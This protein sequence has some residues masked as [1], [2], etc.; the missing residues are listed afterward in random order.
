M[1]KKMFGSWNVVL[2]AASCLVE[3]G[4]AQEKPV[5]TAIPDE[6][7][8]KLPEGVTY[9]RSVRNEPR[10]LQIH[11]LVIDM[12]RA[13][14]SFEVVPGEDPDGDGPAEVALARPEDLA[15]KAGAIA[16]INTAA[17]AMLVD[18]E[19]G[20]PGKYK[21]GGAADISGWVSQG[22]RMISPPQGGYWSVWMDGSNR[23]S[24]GTISSEKELRSKGIEA[25]W[26]VSGFRGILKD[27]KVL[28]DPQ[29][30][31]HPRTAV[32]LSADG[33]KFVWLVV[34]G[35]QKGYSE[36]VSEEELA[37]LLLDNGC[38]HGINLDG[39][40]SSSMWIRNER[41]ELALANRPSDP[42][43]VRPVPVI[44]GMLIK[45]SEVQTKE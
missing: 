26:A 13:E 20:K 37:R 41:S 3:S 32:G 34:D 9:E 14:V 24:M 19:T 35:R 29:E 39:G 5:E 10:P 42:T 18:P 36:G 12:Q 40:G 44:L 30:V 31:R 22:Q 8:W 45:S 17:W 38:A 43:G 28:V 1:V 11:S 7:A 6:T 16:A 33:H 23:I 2:V 27:S 21:V 15:K 4:M 25:K